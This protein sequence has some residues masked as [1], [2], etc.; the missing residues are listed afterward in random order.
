MNH[1]CLP[2]SDP[3]SDIFTMDK[4]LGRIE[5]P[6]PI[7]TNQPLT[8]RNT[9]LPEDFDDSDFESHDD[10]NMI[11][12]PT[13]SAFNNHSLDDLPPSYEEAQAQASRDI[14]EPSRPQPNDLQVHRLVL[15]PNDSQASLQSQSTISPIQPSQSSQTTQP[16]QRSQP[17]QQAY[18]AQ[19]EE[20]SRAELSYDSARAIEA[21][22]A[23]TFLDPLLSFTQSA[24]NSDADYASYLSRRVAIPPSYDSDKVQFARAYGKTLHAHSI[25]PTE[26]MAFVD[27]LNALL[28]SAPSAGEAQQALLAIADPVS[29]DQPPAA[30]IIQRY[31]YRANA[32]FFAPRGVV[33]DLQTLPKLLHHL[34]QQKHNG[35]RIDTNYLRRAVRKADNARDAGQALE[36]YSEPLSWTVPPPNTNYLQVFRTEMPSQNGVI[37][38]TGMNSQ[39]GSA[40][41]A[42]ALGISEQPGNRDTTLSNNT[43]PSYHTIDQAKGEIDSQPPL[44]PT[45]AQ[46]APPQVS[47]MHAQAASPQP[48]GLS[49]GTMTPA[50]PGLAGNIANWGQD[51]GR[52]MEQWGEDQGRSWGNWGVEQGKFWGN[53]GQNIG[54]QIERSLTG[55]SSST[56]EDNVHGNNRWRAARGGPWG[57]G[58][59]GG[60]NHRGGALGRHCGPLGHRGGLLGY[61]GPLGP[62]GLLGHNGPLGPNN[63]V[64]QHLEAIHTRRNRLGRRRGLPPWEGQDVP[65]EENMH[66]CGRR[67]RRHGRGGR[68]RGGRRDASS[69]SSS[70]SDSD[71]DSETDDEDENEHFEAHE[72]YIKRCDSIEKKYRQDS[73]AL[74]EKP[75]D[76][77]V[78]KLHQKRQ[79]DLGKAQADK[80]RADVKYSSRRYKREQRAAFRKLRRELKQDKRR[81]KNECRRGACSRDEVRA[82][83]TQY[84]ETIAKV[85][86][87][88]K[89]RVK[90]YQEEVSQNNTERYWENM[91]M[92]SGTGMPGKSSW[93]VWLVIE[94]LEGGVEQDA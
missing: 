6:P 86:A 27:G 28:A 9:T 62:G 85:A 24:V 15:V 90:Q 18:Q 60:W 31:L 41:Q 78:A 47:A 21:S 1:I 55:D 10:G 93:M 38:S 69:D 34:A 39:S 32:H 82:A 57:H 20:I 54:K 56:A 7:L 3:P 22:A 77:D 94:D 58:R 35:R 12:T 66:R 50:S 83:K 29:G 75:R 76:S 16:L 42:R 87:E 45:S 37:G 64:A 13:S 48:S 33:A 72:Q 2:R 11:L 74:G 68:H 80:A 73:I 8:P 43:L 89:Q 92:A 4:S 88:Y 84:R 70:D 51:F 5:T 63:L 14:G 26:F 36:P 61:N 65:E 23:D 49:S 81:V 17:P 52:R 46:R 71:S 53:W 40:G 67:G 59:H 25:S 79:K 44:Q 91:D 19:I 30:D